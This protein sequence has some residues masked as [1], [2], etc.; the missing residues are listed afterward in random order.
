MPSLPSNTHRETQTHT[1]AYTRTHTHTVLTTLYTAPPHSCLS[2]LGF[3][4]GQLCNHWNELLIRVQAP[5]HITMH[6]HWSAATVWM[7]VMLVYVH[8]YVKMCQSANVPASQSS[9]CTWRIKNDCCSFPLWPLHI[10]LQ[11]SL[12]AGSIGSAGW[13][14]HF[15]PTSASSSSFLPFIEG[16]S[17]RVLMKVKWM[18]E[19][20]DGWE[21]ITA[22]SEDA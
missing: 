21:V 5:K 3:C 17:L 10:T 4:E 6:N 18:K 20:G 9:V 22:G 11:H 14:F 13:R 7:C 1:H 12:K 16:K 15:S 2:P 19:K 8:E